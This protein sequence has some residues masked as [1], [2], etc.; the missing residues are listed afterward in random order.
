MWIFVTQ[1]TDFKLWANKCAVCDA[2]FLWVV[3]PLGKM[4]EKIWL[5]CGLVATPVCQALSRHP[6]GQTFRKFY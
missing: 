4:V 1:M 3:D 2:Y 6:Q 5:E